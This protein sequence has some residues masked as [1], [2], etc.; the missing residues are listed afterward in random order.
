[1]PY[2]NGDYK[3]QKYLHCGLDYTWNGD[4]EYYFW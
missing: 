4:R 2:A 3:N 1:M